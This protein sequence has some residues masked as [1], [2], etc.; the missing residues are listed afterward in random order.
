MKRENLKAGF[1]YRAE[2]LRQRIGSRPL[3]LILLVNLV[4]IVLVGS[5][6]LL[7][8]ERKTNPLIQTYGDALWC[9][10]ITIATVGYGDK[11]PITG[12]G[13]LTVVLMI[14]FG[15]GALT[16]YISQRS[17]QRVQKMQRR[18]SDLDPK[19][20][21]RGH[22]VVCGWNSRGPYVMEMLKAELEKERTQIILLCDLPQAP[23]DDGYTFYAKGNAANV[24]SLERVNIAEA[25]AAI[26]L[27]DEVGDGA[28]CD[29]DARTVLAALN[30]RSINPHIRMTAEVRD[31]ANVHHLEL[32]GVGEILDSDMLLGNMMARSA[33]HYGL[34]GAVSRLVTKEKDEKFYQL[35]VDEKIASL[36]G[37]EVAAF[38]QRE[39]GA[40]LVA[41]RSGDIQV[42]FTED[43]TLRE[44]DLLIVVSGTDPNDFRK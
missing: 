33:L 8:F 16:A 25:K 2:S 20:K 14:V 10:V 29:T 37:G 38:I 34:I 28:A 23:I 5:L 11:V 18:S 42:F 4:V 13:K 7:A 35:S 36:K 12:G 21:S 41:V 30:I 19:M 1:T 39:Y 3:G 43:T 22:F 9:T 32:A 15:I 31:P 44:G 24:K 27:A 6:I 26:L 40:V 17:A